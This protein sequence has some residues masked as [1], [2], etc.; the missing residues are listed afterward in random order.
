MGSNRL[1]RSNGHDSHG[2]QRTY[3]RAAAADGGP[4]PS[5]ARTLVQIN[6]RDP[7]D[8]QASKPPLFWGEAWADHDPFVALSA[9]TLGRAEP[10]PS[11]VVHRSYR[12]QPCYILLNK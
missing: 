11:R 6:H 7:Y 12:W 4:R 5:A 8:A 10:C 9:P 3:F 2:I 1:V